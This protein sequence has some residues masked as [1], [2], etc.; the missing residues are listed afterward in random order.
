M[1]SSPAIIFIFSNFAKLGD[2]ILPPSKRLD[3]FGERIRDGVKFPNFLWLRFY[4][5]VSIIFII[6]LDF[7]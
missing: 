4:L 6:I 2:G 7:S 1:G 5:G 3:C